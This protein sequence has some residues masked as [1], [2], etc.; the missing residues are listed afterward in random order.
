MAKK[1]QAIIFESSNETSWIK[2]SNFSV[3]SC[4]SLG[5]DQWSPTTFVRGPVL[6]DLG[7]HLRPMVLQLIITGL[8]FV[9]VNILTWCTWPCN[10]IP[11]SKWKQKPN[12]LGGGETQYIFAS[13][14]KWFR[15]QMLWLMPG[16][17]FSPY[18]KL[19]PQLKKLTNVSGLW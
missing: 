15:K 8:D 14:T 7:G 6:D 12:V 5:L 3:S 13:T 16:W 1:N 10:T 17:F 11:H 18:W 4:Q 19:K 2:I 9:H